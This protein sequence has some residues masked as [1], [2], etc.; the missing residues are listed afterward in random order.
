MAKLLWLRSSQNGLHTGSEGLN[1][2]GAGLMTEGLVGRAAKEDE[3]EDDDVDGTIMSELGLS[4]QTELGSIILTPT[5]GAPVAVIE[6]VRRPRVWGVEDARGGDDAPSLLGGGG[7]SPCIKGG[8]GEAL[9][10]ILLEL[11]SAV[12]EGE[13]RPS[14]G[15]KLDGVGSEPGDVGGW[16]TSLGLKGDIAGGWNNSA[17]IRTAAAVVIGLDICD[18]R[19]ESNLWLTLAST[20]G[21][22][23]RKEVASWAQD[24]YPVW[25]RRSS[26]MGF[27]VLRHLACCILCR[28]RTVSSRMSAFSSLDTFS[29]WAWSA[30]VIMSLSS[31]RHLLI[32]ARRL[33]SRS[34]F[35]IWKVTK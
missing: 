5:P 11:A 30:A 2:I 18:E 10:E 7:L 31:S 26:S 23:I 22:F 24:E 20:P 35:M 25:K 3:D 28:C 15:C 27:L 13:K 33:R 34:G 8:D 21:V 16:H 12:D 17:G 29:P 6:T 19:Y 32:L 14:L 9:I 4:P 1:L